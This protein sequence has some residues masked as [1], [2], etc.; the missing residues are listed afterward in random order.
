MSTTSLRRRG[1][2]IPLEPPVPGQEEAHYE[3]TG[4]FGDDPNIFDHYASPCEFRVSNDPLVVFDQDVCDAT[5]YGCTGDHSFLVQANEDVRPL[6]LKYEYDLYFGYDSTSHEFQDMVDFI[7][8]T[9]LEHMAT[10]LGLKDCNGAS[11]IVR[12]RHNNNRRKL[13]S[14]T[15]ELKAAFV[16]INSEPGDQSRS[17]AYECIEAPQQGIKC[18]AMVGYMTLYMESS[19]ASTFQQSTEMQ[20][21]LLEAIQA[22]MESDVYV[23]GAIQKLV[24][25]GDRSAGD[26]DTVVDETLVNT[27][28]VEV[29]NAPDTEEPFSIVIPLDSA[30]PVVPI[31][32]AEEQNRAVDNEGGSRALSNTEIG[33]IAGGASFLFLLVLLAICCFCKRRR[34]RTSDSSAASSGS[35]NEVP[36][37]MMIVEDDGDATREVGGSSICFKRRR[38]Q[39][40]IAP[41]KY[42]MEGAEIPGSL[43]AMDALAL[44]PQ[45]GNSQQTV[46]PEM[47]NSLHMMQRIEVGRDTDD[48]GLSLPPAIP[49]VVKSS[50]SSMERQE[51]QV[52]PASQVVVDQGQEMTATYTM[53]TV[54][55]SPVRNSKSGISPSE[56]SPKRLPPE[57]NTPYVAPPVANQ[58]SES[59]AVKS[60]DTSFYGSAMSTLSNLRRIVTS[61]SDSS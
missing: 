60:R 52:P 39:K 22:G 44:Q 32:V 11:A 21:A 4:G 27:P 6:E 50:S 20:D 5:I 45:V 9:M 61:S 38:R 36:T 47:I 34:R 26:G 28:L 56:V 15:D 25:V 10:L 29:T 30:D 35:E 23:K 19:M 3:F 59:F 1:Q 46:P 41:S 43:A 49:R 53:S 17:P 54:P 18:E 14:F 40:K 12:R 7:E 51:R 31:G 37:K 13:E 2:L 33:L 24:Y 16:A 8:G 48:D 55:L 57:L 42:G 58:E